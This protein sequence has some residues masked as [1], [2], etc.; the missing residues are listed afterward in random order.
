MIRLCRT[1]SNGSSNKS[2][3]SSDD[4][5]IQ[6]DSKSVTI[7]P[8]CK[9]QPLM[10]TEGANN[11]YSEDHKTQS[12]ATSPDVEACKPSSSSCTFGEITETV[13]L[14]SA[15]ICL[16][17]GAAAISCSR[18]CNDNP[19][20]DVKEV[21]L[22]SS[23]F[24]EPNADVASSPRKLGAL[25]PIGSMSPRN[26]IFREGPRSPNSAR[27]GYVYALA[28]AISQMPEEEQ[29]NLARQLMASPRSSGMEVMSIVDGNNIFRDGTKIPSSVYNDYA[30]ALADVISKMPEE[31]HMKLARQLSMTSPMSA[32]SSANGNEFR[33]GYSQALADAISQMPEDEQINLARQLSMASPKSCCMDMAARS[34]DGISVHRGTSGRMETAPNGV[35]LRKHWA[36]QDIRVVEQKSNERDEPEQAQ[37]KRPLKGFRKGIKRLAKT[38]LAVIRQV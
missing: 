37:G 3:L 23:S 7:C 25:S 32:D 34:T 24:I 14:L 6:R 22:D 27:N 28:D 8:I 33:N 20:Y 26:D 38:R 36:A 10:T 2:L 29:M 31:E 21:R 4:K 19:K 30:H 11:A 17:A 9:E 16:G 5:K 18:A 13:G 12:S 35:V 1:A 15:R